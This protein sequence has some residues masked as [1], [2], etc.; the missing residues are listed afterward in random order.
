MMMSSQLQSGP[1]VTRREALQRER[2][3]SSGRKFRC[4]E[5]G[6][7]TQPGEQE[8]ST[9]KQNTEQRRVLRAKYRQLQQT[10]TGTSLSLSVV[11]NDVMFL[12]LYLSLYWQQW[13][14]LFI[15]CF[16]GQGRTHPAR[17]K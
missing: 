3:E 4:L 8:N 17:L 15:L 12:G 14:E 9:V 7:G 11:Q 2:G 10:I 5:D 6:L 1:R 13:Y 16:R